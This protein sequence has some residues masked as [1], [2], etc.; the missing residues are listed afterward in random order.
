MLLENPKIENLKNISMHST[1]KMQLLDYMIIIHT[2]NPL[3]FFYTTIATFL[4]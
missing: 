3:F 1:H 2:L 4:T